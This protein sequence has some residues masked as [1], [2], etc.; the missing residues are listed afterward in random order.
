V[1]DR[2]SLRAKH[3]RGLKAQ[4]PPLDTLRYDAASTAEDG[5]TLLFG[6]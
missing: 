4:T 2:N 1:G 3:R 5:A 6:R